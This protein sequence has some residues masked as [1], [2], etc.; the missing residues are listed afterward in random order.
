M[1][2]EAIILGGEPL[3]HPNIVQLIKKLNNNTGLKKI[4]LTTNAIALINNDNLIKEIFN[5]ID[6]LYGINISSHNNED[7]MTYDKLK[8]ICFKIK[9]VNPNIKIRIN[10]NIYK[11]NLDNI[12]EILKHIQII[13][14]FSDEM[15]ISN[16][17]PKDDF[18]VNNIN[19]ADDLILSNKQYE[20]LFNQLINHYADKY[21][22]IENDKTL[23]FVK[24]LLIPAKFPIIINWNINST[25]A[26]QICE[27]DINNR[28]INTFKCLVNGEISLSW[29]NSNIINI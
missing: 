1:I 16:I 15:R 17:I 28:F 22:I 26:E 18:S 10:S 3:L 23:G 2:Q 24:Y 25:V 14:E 6:G 13:S 19:H 21:T 9:T 4:R 29:N 7:F 12:D 20:D 8:E 27:N 11:N 5:P